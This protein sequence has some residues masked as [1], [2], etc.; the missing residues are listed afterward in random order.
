M[1]KPDML[2]KDYVAKLSEDNLK[3]LNSR[4]GQRL[5]GDLPEA[6]NFLSGNH[7][8]DRYLAA[9][10]TCNELYD[11]ADQLELAVDREYDRRYGN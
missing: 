7:E 9:A 8:M 1:K 4:L 5:S 10:K 3:F 11:I 6:L 2:V